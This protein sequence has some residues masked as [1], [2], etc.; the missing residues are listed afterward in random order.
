MSTTRPLMNNVIVINRFLHYSLDSS[1]ESCTLREAFLAS[2]IKGKLVQLIAPSGLLP[3][4]FPLKITNPKNP[5][6]Y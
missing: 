6:G 4:T 3:L 2:Q 5:K 1:I